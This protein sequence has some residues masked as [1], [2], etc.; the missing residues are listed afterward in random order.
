MKVAGTS[1]R[2]RCPGRLV[3]IRAPGGDR[4]DQG[5]WWPP[6]GGRRRWLGTTTRGYLNPVGHRRIH[7]S[8]L[9]GGSIIG[10]HDSAPGT[11]LHQARLC[12]YVIDTIR[13]LQGFVDYMNQHH[14][15]VTVDVPQNANGSAVPNVPIG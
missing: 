15:D 2:D 11:C 3:A 12:S 7:I 10:F 13:A 5:S 4:R 14:L 9:H 1:W 6:T 8:A